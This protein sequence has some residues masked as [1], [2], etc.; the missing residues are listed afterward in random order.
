MTLTVTPTST[1][2][3]SPPRRAAVLAGLAGPPLGL[4]ALV[5]PER[6]GRYPTCPFRWATGLD[7]PGCGSLR[8]LHDLLHG[9]VLQ[10][11]DHNALL[12]LLL[13]VLVLGAVSWVRGRPQPALFLGR[14]F[15][16][17]VLVTVLV[18]AVARNLP[19]G[20][21]EVLASS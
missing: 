12:V 14:R 7:C 10:A 9:G 16:R 19:F 13:P 21:L 20:V 5:D 18:W 4:L 11:V 15:G 1:A 3:A 2:T 6:P 17:L 8:A